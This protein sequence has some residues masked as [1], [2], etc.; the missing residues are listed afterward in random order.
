MSRNER[1]TQESTGP[2]CS[3][4]VEACPVCDAAGMLRKH[5]GD[6][7]RARD[8]AAYARNDYTCKECGAYVSDDDVNRRP[9][10]AEGHQANAAGSFLL[11]EDVTSWEEAREA[12]QQAGGDA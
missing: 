10:K 2:D 9:P 7:K 5:Q 3:Q 1:G 6:P 12:S 11:R 8:A 4:L